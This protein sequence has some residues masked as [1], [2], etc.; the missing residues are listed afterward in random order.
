[1]FH[2][3]LKKRFSNDFVWHPRVQRYAISDVTC[4]VVDV[5]NLGQNPRASSWI[6]NLGQKDGIPLFLHQCGDQYIDFFLNVENRNKKHTGCAFSWLIDAVFLRHHRW[7]PEWAFLTILGRTFRLSLCLLTDMPVWGV[8][9][10]NF[11]S[12]L[13]PCYIIDIP[14]LLQRASPTSE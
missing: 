13:K 8:R 9:I 2:E 1:M 6:A 7:L 5:K 10:C 14:I 4:Q 11:W 3:V 12:S